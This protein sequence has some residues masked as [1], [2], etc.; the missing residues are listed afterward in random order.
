MARGRGRHHAHKDKNHDEIVETVRAAGL[1]VKDTFRVGGGFPD[2]IVS[3]YS[4]LTER[5]ETLFVEIK[6]NENAKV[7]ES[8]IEWASDFQGEF[9]I[10]WTAEQILEWFGRVEEEKCRIP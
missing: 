6:E 1:G 10:A 5:R 3:G 2:I 4:L 9:M 8:Q 7:R